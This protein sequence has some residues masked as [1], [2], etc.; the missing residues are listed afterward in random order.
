M[1]CGVRI[2]RQDGQRGAR[3]PRRSM[4][5]VKIRIAHYRKTK[6][7]TKGGLSRG[8]SALLTTEFLSAF[9]LGVM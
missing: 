8:A 4:K 2:A 5:K 1:H 9:F 7:L 3:G 6:Y